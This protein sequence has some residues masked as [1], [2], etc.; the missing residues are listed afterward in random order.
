MRRSLLLVAIVCYEFYDYCEVNL[1]LLSKMLPETAFSRR[2]NFGH[3]DGCRSAVP[4]TTRE[5]APAG[6]L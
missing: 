6:R 1:I 4:G 5:R 3:D 2:A